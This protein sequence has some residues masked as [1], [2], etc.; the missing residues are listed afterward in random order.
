[1][2]DQTCNQTCNQFATEYITKQAAL[3]AI[4]CDIT[5]TGRRNAELVAETIGAFADRI[6]EMQPVEPQRIK[7]RWLITSAYP[8]NV[9]C[10]VCYTKFAQTHWEVWKD[11]SLPRNF[12]PNC[13]ADMREEQNGKSE[14]QI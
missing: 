8:H 11:G 7:G 12:C 1:M 10:S 4:S 6:K 14:R 5:I 13:G 2:K 9:H 3:D